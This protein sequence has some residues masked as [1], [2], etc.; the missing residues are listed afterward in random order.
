MVTAPD[1]Q[2][3]A[4]AASI[5]QV[6]RTVAGD[7]LGWQRVL[8]F[9]PSTR[10]YLRLSVQ[11]DHEAWLLSWLPGQHTGWHDHG[12][13]AGA[14]VVAFGA[15]QEEST[16]PGGRMAARSVTAGRHRAFGPRH[17]HNVSNVSDRPAVSV[18]VYSP[19][20]TSMNRYELA[21]GRLTHL[22][23]DTAGV[24]W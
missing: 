9:D 17:V 22:R 10:W 12:G 23:S 13:S 1:P 5:L 4:S 11:D 15:L 6:A 7:P 16:L 18:H 24:G 8:H 2:L 20:L 21:G 19:P 14:F 3:V